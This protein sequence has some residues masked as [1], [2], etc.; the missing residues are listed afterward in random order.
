MGGGLCTSTCP[1]VSGPDFESKSVERSSV[2]GWGI[3]R[4]GVWVLYFSVGLVTPVW[5]R[6]FRC[7]Q[8]HNRGRRRFGLLKRS[9]GETV[10]GCKR[11]SEFEFRR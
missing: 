11:G 8:V 1:L 10:S 5:Y 9:K 3:L 4:K 7:V 6:S 2:L